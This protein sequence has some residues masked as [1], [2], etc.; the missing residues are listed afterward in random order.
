[1]MN[2]LAPIA[3]STYSRLEHLRKTVSTL[4]KNTL[5]K[6]SDLYIF[7]D[8][9][10]PG[11]EEK[12][13]QVR[14][15]IHTVTGFKNVY[16][17]EREK[18]N[19]ILNNRGGM[20]ML[21]EKSG[22]M[23]FL[24]EDVA[25]SPN[26]LAFIN[27]SLNRY[28]DNN[29][30]FSISGYCP[31]I[32]IPNNYAYDGFFLRRFNAWGFG[33]WKDRY[34]KIQYV[35]EYDLNNLQSDKEKFKLFCAYGKDMIG[36]LKAD[37]N[38]DIDALDVKAMYAQFVSNQFTLYPSE[39]LTANNGFDGTGLH[40]G[41]TDKFNVSLSDKRQFNLPET[42]ILNKEIIKSNFNFRKPSLMS[43]IKPMVK[44]YLIKR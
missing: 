20:Q 32:N 35:S 42:V 40:C 19:R 24:E 33:I 43:M 4:Q 39:S 8:G 29:E 10:K 14:Q 26:F 41:V 25:T 37:V 17:Y 12:V 27:Q 13:N 23:I 30:I 18:N 22:K 34:E 15:Y 2:N 1:M 5:A 44:K 28:Q 38:K 36:M 31:P 7:S 21:L 6:D 9:A 11:D 3:L 16:I